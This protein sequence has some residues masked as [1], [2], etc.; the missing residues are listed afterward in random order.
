MALA[1]PQGSHTIDTAFPR[2]SCLAPQAQ[3]DEIQPRLREVTGILLRGSQCGVLVR[4][5][6]Q[7]SDRC[8]EQQVCLGV[9]RKEL[10]PV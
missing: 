9:L 3:G 7:N 6:H 8:K 2:A 4:M 5:T 1:G 10:I